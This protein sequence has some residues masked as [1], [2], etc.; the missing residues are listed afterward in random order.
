M[1]LGKVILVGLLTFGSFTAVDMISTTKQAAAATQ[2]NLSLNLSAESYRQGQN[3]IFKLIN[4]TDQKAHF[5]VSTEKLSKDGWVYYDAYPYHTELPANTWEEGWLESGWGG[6][7][8]E[9]GTYRFKV[10]TTKADGTKNIFYSEM[11]ELAKNPIM[12]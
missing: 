11:F 9:S 8:V 7:I 5:Y 2:D 3:V 4:D 6:I 10:E 1:K 12:E